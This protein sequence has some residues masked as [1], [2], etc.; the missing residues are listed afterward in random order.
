MREHHGDA[1]GY[2]NQTAYPKDEI[3]NVRPDRTDPRRPTLQADDDE[4]VQDRH[5][6]EQ[7]DDPSYEDDQRFGPRS[8]NQGGNIV[9]DFDDDAFDAPD[10]DIGG[11]VIDDMGAPPSL[12]PG[13]IPGGDLGYSTTLL[14]DV[15]GDKGAV[16]PVMPW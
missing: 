10:D 7:D 13:V 12:E 11:N 15:V 4:Q 2:S 5:H 16:A 9:D 14:R 1:P 6:V 3:E 8:G